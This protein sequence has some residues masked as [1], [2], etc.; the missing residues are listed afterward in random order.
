M[1][2]KKVFISFE[3]E[4]DRSLKDLLIGQSLNPETPFEVIDHSL[5]E[6]APEKEWEEKAQ[7]KIKSADIVIVIL[8]HR[9]HVAPGVLREVKMARAFHKKI[10]QLIGYKEGKYQRVPGAGVLYRW[11]WD[12][13][14]KILK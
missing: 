3:Y 2:K 6:A 11:S 4:N 5:H 1:A 13:L 8:G 14:K 12:N 7:K 10:V 9:T